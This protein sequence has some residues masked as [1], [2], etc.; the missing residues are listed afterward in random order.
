MEIDELDWLWKLNFIFENNIIVQMKDNSNM[1]E[2]LKAIY[3]ANKQGVWLWVQDNKTRFKSSSEENDVLE[4]MIKLRK[5]KDE[6]LK[7]L[8][9]NWVL[10][11]QSIQP[12]IYQIAERESVLSFAQ[13]RLWFIE[14]FE[15]GTNAYHIP[16]VF[17][18]GEMTS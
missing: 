5:Y 17:E 1:Q 4:I 2:A 12:Y 7:I 11:D 8:V 16:V 14:Q 18:L 15:Q 9:Y 10:S 3:E 13:E 6:I